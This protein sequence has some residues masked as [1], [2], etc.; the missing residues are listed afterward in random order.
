MTSQIEELQKLCANG[1]T[2]LIPLHPVENEKQARIT[3]IPLAIDELE[4]FSEGDLDSPEENM[5]KTLDLLAKS[6]EISREEA[7][8]IPLRYL[9]DILECI[10][11]INNLTEGSEQGNKIKEFIQQKQQTL[12]T[13]KDEIVTGNKST[14]E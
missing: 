1:Q 13:E 10:L 3:L 12:K 2:Y 14:K 8:K 5:R 11:T 7:K 9:N 6:M 4:G